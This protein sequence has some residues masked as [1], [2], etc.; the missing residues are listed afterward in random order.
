MET[1]KLILYALSLCFLFQAL[2][3]YDVSHDG[4]AITID[5]QRRVLLSGSIHYPR[6][7]LKNEMT[8]FT[9][10][11]VEMMRKEKL[12]ASQGGPIVEMMET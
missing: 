5:G 4:R 2:I 12:F 1:T 7:T 11:I 3:A 6:S 10:L 9:T 8:N